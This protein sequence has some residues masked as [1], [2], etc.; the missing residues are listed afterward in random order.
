MSQNLVTLD[1][2]K[3]PVRIS[4]GW[5]A[6][7]KELFCRVQPL[8]PNNNDSDVDAF[9]EFPCEFPGGLTQ[10]CSELGTLHLSIPEAMLNMVRQD[11]DTYAGN[12]IREFSADGQLLVEK[13]FA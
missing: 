10:I 5:D 13:S 9:M 11:A 3:G 2:S 4:M 12:V 7:L 6:P 1:S 8:A